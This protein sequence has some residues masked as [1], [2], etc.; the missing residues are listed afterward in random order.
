MKKTTEPF[1]SVCMAK[2]T[3][4]LP[5]DTFVEKIKAEIAEKSREHI[6]VN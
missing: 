4:V 2:E 3:T 5:L 1:P 6:H